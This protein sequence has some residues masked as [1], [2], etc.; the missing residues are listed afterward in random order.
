MII[1]QLANFYVKYFTNKLWLERSLRCGAHLV[2]SN[3]LLK[4][5]FSSSLGCFFIFHRCKIIFAD[6]E[7]F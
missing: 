7:L 4:I 6:T 2:C 3:L 5:I 1:R